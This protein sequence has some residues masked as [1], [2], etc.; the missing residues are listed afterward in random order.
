M[1][2]HSVSPSAIKSYK[3]NRSTLTQISAGGSGMQNKS[4]ISWSKVQ[5]Q[6]INH[7]PAGWCLA[8]ALF[9][10]LFDVRQL[11]QGLWENGIGLPIEKI[12]HGTS[13]W[14][15][16]SLKSGRTCV[17]RCTKLFICLHY[18]IPNFTQRS[19][20]LLFPRLVRKWSSGIH[21]FGSCGSFDKVLKILKSLEISNHIT[22]G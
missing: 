13:E 20:S 16:K 9:T 4:S 21:F 5:C 12:L 22:A 18:R 10:W 17:T 6:V 15:Y 7:V 2:C 11:I 1:T 8:W 14:N 3:I 19:K